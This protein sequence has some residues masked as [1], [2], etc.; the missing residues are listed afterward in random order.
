MAEQFSSSVGVIGSSVS[1][2]FA[3]FDIGAPA[4][5]PEYRMAVGQSAKGRGVQCRKRM[6]GI[7]L[8]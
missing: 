4:G 8:Y 5:L 3:E 7:T 1:A 6:K 2:R